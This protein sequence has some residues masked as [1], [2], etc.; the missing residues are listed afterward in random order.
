[1]HFEIPPLLDM[2]DFY[3]EPTHLSKLSFQIVESSW[4]KFLWLCLWTCLSAFQSAIVKTNIF[5][6]ISSELTC[7]SSRFMSYISIFDWNPSHSTIF[8]STYEALHGPNLAN[9]DVSVVHLSFLEL[10]FHTTPIFY[11]HNINVLINSS[12]CQLASIYTKVRSTFE[13]PLV[14]ICVVLIKGTC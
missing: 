13:I 11:S 5:S 7:H 14:T 1:M 8:P 9:S 3:F 2:Q 10:L 4:F 6:G 12:S